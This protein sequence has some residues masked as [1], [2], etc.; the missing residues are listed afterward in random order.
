[1]RAAGHVELAH[2]VLQMVEREADA[3]RAERVGEQDVGAGVDEA[4]MDAL[5]RLRA[6]D[7]PRRAVVAFAEAE[8][9]EIGAHRAV[10]DDDLLLFE[11]PAQ[12]I[13]HRGFPNGGSIGDCTI[14]V[15]EK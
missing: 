1:M 10:G 6:L 15:R 5:H 14:D 11:E 3:I 2:A 8:R 4:L 9:E 7:V 13:A 12:Q